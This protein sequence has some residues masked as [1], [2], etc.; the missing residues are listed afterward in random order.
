MW[1]DWIVNLL[2]PA[3]SSLYEYLTLVKKGG[4]K[5]HDTSKLLK[6]ILQQ[7]CEELDFWVNFLVIKSSRNNV[8][9]KEGWGSS[10]MGLTRAWEVKEGESEEIRS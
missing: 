6:S 5:Q 1:Y 4:K 9:E 3:T 10:F 2:P 7:I 8:Y